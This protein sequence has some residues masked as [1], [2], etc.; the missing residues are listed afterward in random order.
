MAASSRRTSDLR[1]LSIYGFQAVEGGHNT[2]ALLEFDVTGLRKALR[3]ARR[4]GR[5]GSLFAFFVKAIALCLKAHPDF[6]SMVDRRRTTA[7]DEVDVSVPIEVSRGGE[8]YNRQLVIRDADRKGVH[9]IDREIEA[10]RTADDGSMSYLPSPALRRLVAFLPGFAVRALFR[11]VMRSHRM[12]KAASGTVFVTSV[13]MF[14][15]GSGF[16]LPYLGGPKA[17]SFAIG[18]VARK[19]VAVRDGIEVR[20]MVNVTAAFNHD[21]IDGAPAARF[22]GEL[23][24]IVESG[25]GEA[26]G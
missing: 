18:G 20:E 2:Y 9:E 17:S 8:V 7:F 23:K 1:K 16:V 24:R 4:A 5:G 13:S 12:V 14:S 6:N 11:V 21:L 19:P 25:Y 26:L 22:V 10:A 15:T 3:E